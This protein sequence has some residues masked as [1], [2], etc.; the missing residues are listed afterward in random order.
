MK[1]PYECLLVFCSFCLLLQGV[2]G[3]LYPRES[4]S[5][6]VKELNGL[7]H[8]RADYS[9]DRNE[10]FEKEWYKQPLS[11]VIICRLWKWFHLCYTIAWLNAVI[12][13]TPPHT[14][15]HTHR[16]VMWYRCQYR[17]VSMIL[18]RMHHWGTL[19][20]GCGTIVSSGY[21][22]LGVTK[23]FESCYDLKVLITTQ[24]LWVCTSRAMNF[25]IS[26]SSG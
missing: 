18:L 15:T 5:R 9:E 22:P 6:E 3:L 12:N 11:K 17:P 2:L 26:L 13:I 20:G 23:K 1:P 14:H 10:G 16:V 25:N 8:F 21:Q 4:S 19:W 24:L 7:W